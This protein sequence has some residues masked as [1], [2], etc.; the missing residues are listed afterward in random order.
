[1]RLGKTG[2][3]FMNCSKVCYFKILY[4]SKQSAGDD[5]D[6]RKEAKTVERTEQGAGMCCELAKLK[7]SKT[8]EL[9]DHVNLSFQ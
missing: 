3:G 9:N 2:Q 7:T 1:M 5:K 4:L 6:G 8:T